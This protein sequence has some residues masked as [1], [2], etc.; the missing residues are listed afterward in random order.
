MNRRKFLEIS[1]KLAGAIA[2]PFNLLT[3]NKPTPPEVRGDWK[4]YPATVKFRRYT[5]LPRVTGPLSEG[6]VPTGSN[7]GFTEYKTVKEM[8]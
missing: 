3:K 2:L 1:I 8:N 5:S 4:R 7:L 6:I